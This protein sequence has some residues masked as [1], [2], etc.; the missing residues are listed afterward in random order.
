M[1]MP[2]LLELPLELVLAIMRLLGNEDLLRQLSLVCQGRAADYISYSLPTLNAIVQFLHCT[3]LASESDLDCRC[4][5]ESQ[6]H[7][8]SCH[9][10]PPIWD[11]CRCMYRSVRRFH[12]SVLWRLVNNCFSGCRLTGLSPLLAVEPGYRLACNYPMYHLR[13]GHVDRITRGY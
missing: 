1:N 10:R 9:T 8:C 5:D 12:W 7:Q 4:R 11:Y 6:T 3:E 13:F 2:S